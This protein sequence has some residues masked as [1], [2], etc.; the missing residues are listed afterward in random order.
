MNSND[1]VH[2]VPRTEIAAARWLDVDFPGVEFGIAEY[3]EGPTGCTVFHFPEVASMHIDVRGG[4]PGINGEHLT[5]TNAICFAGGSLYGLEASTGVAAELFARRG[6]STKWM[7]IAL[8]SGAIVF[9]YGRRDNAIYPDKELGRAAVRALRPGRFALGPHGAG[10]SAT[11]GHGATAEL[12]GQGGAFRRVGPTRI[13][14][15]TVVN[16]YG[17]IVDRAGNVVRGNRDQASGKRRRAEDVVAET[18]VYD[19]PPGRMRGVTPNT[20]LTL[21]VTDQ[22]LDPLQL[23]SLARQVHSSMARAIQPFHTRW[24]GDILFAVST[25]QV[26]HVALDEV[27]LAI[28]ASELAWDAVLACFDP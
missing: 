19:P 5:L 17:A 21:V 22:K 13:A 10:I 9:D 4:S 18:G 6:Y 1:T 24:D 26:D 27:S 11:A 15:F 23:R 12:S 7:D 28:I 25:Q 20:N 3:A 16:A 8:V 14:V 2:P